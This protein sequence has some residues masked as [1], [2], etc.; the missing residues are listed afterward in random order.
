MRYLRK[1]LMAGMVLLVGVSAALAQMTFTTIDVPGA[2]ITVAD[3]INTAGDVVGYYGQSST[4]PVHGFLLRAGEFAFFDYPGADSTLATAINDSGLIAGYAEFGTQVK[5]FLYDGN[6]F[7]DVTAGNRSATFVMGMNNLGDLVGG[8]GTIYGTQG[9][10]FRIGQFRKI[11]PSGSFDYVY[12]AGI[13][14]LGWI[15]GFTSA[16]LAVHGFQ[17]KHGVFQKVDFPGSQTTELWGI[18]NSGLA[19]GWYGIGNQYSGFTLFRGKYTTFAYPGAQGTFPRSV[20]A[21]GESVGD[22]LL[23][24][25]TVHGF[26]ATGVV[27]VR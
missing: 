9:F 13:S 19:V 24:D 5:G 8:A 17:Y 1:L 16:G 14:D 15:V 6:M 11:Q 26:V 7:T 2:K 25:G 10:L 18:N 21:G 12:A 4:G 22:Y 20:N 27:P 23:S 3:G